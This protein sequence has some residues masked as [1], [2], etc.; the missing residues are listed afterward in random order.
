MHVE[1]IVCIEELLPVVNVQLRFQGVPEAQNR[2][3]WM[4]R[5]GI[6]EGRNLLDFL[7][8]S[9]G[10]DEEDVVHLVGMVCPILQIKVDI[11]T[12][13]AVEEDIWVGLIGEH[14][15]QTGSR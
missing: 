14:E 2:G 6:E 7:E 9:G 13:W 4:R 10:N 12:Q 1:A 11:S 15:K 8:G 3:V 5:T